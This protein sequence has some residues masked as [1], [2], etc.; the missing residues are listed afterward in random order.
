[1]KKVTSREYKVMLRPG[2]FKGREK[3]LLKAAGAFWRDFAKRVA[4]IAVAASGDLAAIT[5][6][7]SITFYDTRDRRL[8][9]ARYIF[10]ERR[11]ADSRERDFTLKFRHSDRYV[12]QDRE[13]DASP[14][15]DA[16]TKFEEDIKGPFVSLY[17]FSTKITVR[18]EDTAFKTVEDLRRRFPGIVERVDRL[19]DA[20]RLSA[21]NGFTARELVLTGAMLQ[22]GRTPK[23]DAECALIVWYD[24]D[25]NSQKPVAVEFSYRY[26]D[27]EEAY[28]GGTTRRAFEIF[29]VLQSKL[30]KWVDPK[31]RTKTA[32][33][34]Q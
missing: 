30:S 8:N 14:P 5:T 1:M 11:E 4:D 33:V 21:V 2:R 18:D 34:Y 10:R 3:A 19:D 32:F 23:V 17:S 22:V 25:G 28:G 12:T 31:P 26:G 15:A 24:E 6:R 29:N 7:R 27:K 13:M 9:Q 16:K 20:A